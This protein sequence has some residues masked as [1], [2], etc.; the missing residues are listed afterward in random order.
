V[1]ILVVFNPEAGHGRARRRLAEIENNI[2]NLGHTADVLLTGGPGDAV[3]IVRSADLERYDAVAAAGG[4][5]TLFEVVNGLFQ[6]PEGPPIPLAV[7]PLGTGNSFSLD[8]GLGDQPINGSLEAISSGRTRRVDV[9]R[10]RTPDAEIFFVNVIGLGFVTD[11]S[12]IAARLKLLGNA[13]YT[14][15]V[16]FRTLALRS[17]PMVLEIDG[18][19]IERESIFLEVMNSRYTADFLMAPEARIDDGRLDLTLLG[20]ITRRRLLRLFPTVFKGTHTQY[21]EV[22]IFTARRIRISTSRPEALAP[23]GEI[24]GIT[25]VEIECL[26]GA[27]NVFTGPSGAS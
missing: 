4:D 11:V 27:L 10:C 6:R 1:K 8:L 19:K 16:I 5:G 7:F 21:E 18:T 22:E 26:P 20:P 9:G 14:I 15:G 23:D 17:F 25:P 12:A 3:E 24:M 13:A 2:Q